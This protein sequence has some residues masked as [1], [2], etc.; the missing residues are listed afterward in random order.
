MNRNQVS[1]A[2]QVTSELKKSSIFAISRSLKPKNRPLGHFAVLQEPQIDHDP[3]I[4][5]LQEPQIDHDP[6]IA[7]LQEP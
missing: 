6:P 7:V 1:V 4:A 2:D 3:P 5:V